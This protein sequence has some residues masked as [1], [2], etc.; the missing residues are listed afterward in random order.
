[1]SFWAGSAL[2]GEGETN[3]LQLHDRGFKNHLGWA[4]ALVSVQVS[5]GGQVL[6]I[7]KRQIQRRE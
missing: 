5:E 4:L 7:S 6:K 3:H 1:M 2:P